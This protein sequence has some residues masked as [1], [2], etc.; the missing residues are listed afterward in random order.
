MADT[1][2][3][4]VTD[5]SVAPLNDINIAVINQPNPVTNYEATAAQIRSLLYFSKYKMTESA[6]GIP[7]TGRNFYDY[8]PDEN[9]Y[10]GGGGDTPGPGPEPTPTPGEGEMMFSIGDGLYQI[11]GSEHCVV[12]I[13]EEVV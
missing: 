13:V 5:I 12:G 9:P 3:I 4:D 2:T 7:I 6:T 11:P 1:L 8:F 10:A